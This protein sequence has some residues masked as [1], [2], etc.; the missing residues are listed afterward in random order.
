MYLADKQPRELVTT[1]STIGAG[2][3]RL[4][5]WIRNWYEVLSNDSNLDMVCPFYARGG[6]ELKLCRPG[7]MSYAG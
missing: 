2:M 6:G 5:P 3:G 1:T 4:E 7:V